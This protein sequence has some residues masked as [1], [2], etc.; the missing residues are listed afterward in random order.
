MPGNALSVFAL[1]DSRHTD[2]IICRSKAEDYGQ[3]CNQR[4]RTLNSGRFS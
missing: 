2:L 3:K 4:S 1:I